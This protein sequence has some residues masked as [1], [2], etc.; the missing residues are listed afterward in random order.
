M[1][2]PAGTRSLIIAFIPLEGKAIW[3][4]GSLKLTAASFADWTPPGWL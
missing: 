4:P 1:G 2:C 3:I